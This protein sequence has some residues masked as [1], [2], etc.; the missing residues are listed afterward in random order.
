MGGNCS[1]Q[2]KSHARV[3]SARSISSVAN[4]FSLASEVLHPCYVVPLQY[5]MTMDRIEIHEELMEKGVVR[6]Y[7]PANDG[8]ML[9]ISHQWASNA[10]PDPKFKQFSVL[11]DVIRQLMN[12]APVRSSILHFARYGKVSLEKNWK[13]RLANAVV[14]YIAFSTF[15]STHFCSAHLIQPT[16]ICQLFFVL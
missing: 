15:Y 5:V 2:R 1:K 11:Q 8:E 3:K 4:R 9:F 7:D 10:A 6:V 13:K 14:W 16:N 12:G